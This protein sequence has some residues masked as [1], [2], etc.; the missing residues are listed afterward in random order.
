[1]CGA[2]SCWNVGNGGG[3][4]EVVAVVLWWDVDVV[5]V[6]ALWNLV[7]AGGM[8]ALVDSGQCCSELWRP[9]HLHNS[10]EALVF[11]VVPKIDA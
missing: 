7:S 2:K 5:V 9:G 8:C 11:V 4:C 10:T 1:M 3:R 6:I